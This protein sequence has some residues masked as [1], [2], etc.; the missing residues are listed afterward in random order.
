MK[1]SGKQ[2]KFYHRWRKEHQKKLRIG[3]LSHHFCDHVNMRL[4]YAFLGGCNGER[5]EVFA[6]MGGKEDKVTGHLMGLADGWRDISQCTAEEAARQIYEDGI[7]IL[8]DFS[9]NAGNRYLPIL[10]R[11][12]APVQMA[13]IGYPE[14][15]GSS[16]V[17][18]FLGDAF[19]DDG[20]AESK[21]AEEL[22][23]LPQS[24][25]CYMP[26]YGDFL[27][28]EAPCRRNGFVTFGSLCD[29]S[30]LK[31]ATLKAW[32][33]IMDAVPDSRL[34]L[35]A[36]VNDD[37]RNTLKRIRAM[38]IDTERVELR[39]AGQGYWKIYHEIDIAL[40]AFSCSNAGKI[41][42]ALYMGIP[43]VTLKGKS[44][45]E[46]FGWDILQN[47]GL[48]E[49]CARTEE[50]YAERA[51][52]LAGD[53]ELLAALRQ[54]LRG[55]MEN[56]PLMNRKDYMEAVEQGYEMVW[57]HFVAGQTVPS[58]QEARR[59]V[60]IFDELRDMGETKQALAVADRILEAKPESLEVVKKLCAIYIDEEDIEH[61]VRALD[62]MPKDL[63]LGKFLMG[64]MC[65]LQKKWEDAEALCMEVARTGGLDHPLRGAEHHVLGD[66]YKLCG[67]MLKSA[68]EYRLASS[69][70]PNLTIEERM[71]QY[72][73]YL[74]M[75]HFTEQTP[76]FMYREACRYR[77]YVKDVQPFSHDGRR[78][79]EKLRIGYISPDFRRHVVACFSQ[80]FFD[81]AD[82]ERFEVYAYAKC[83]EDDISR[84][85]AQRADVWRNI[86]DCGTRQAAR[87][88]YEDEIDIL[89][90]ISG[91]TA[92]NALTVMAL[93]PA[94][95]QLCGIGYFSTTGL[96]AVDYFLVDEHTAPEGEDAFFSE[97]L[98][99][100]PH[101]HFCYT[102]VVEVPDIASE[103][104]C[105]RNGFI[106]F[107][108]MNNVNKMSDGVLEAWGKLMKEIPES[109]LFL[110][111]GLLDD[112]ARRERE[113]IRLEKVGIDSSR[114]TM[115]GFSGDYLKEYRRMDIALDT[116]PYPGGGT[117][118]D[119][120]YMGVP[121]IT[122]AGSSNHERFGL[123]IL[124]NIG[125]EELCGG[126][127]EEY[128]ACAVG[129][130]RD[131][132]RL[133]KIHGSLRDR[134]AGSAV[135]NQKMYMKDLEEAYEAVWKRY[136]EDFAFGKI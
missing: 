102:Q 131:R 59:L 118:C 39:D 68:E 11:K 54:N 24:I 136:E 64:K 91:H 50:E 98:L 110:K 2:Q 33:G 44:H 108:S 53:G 32:A 99:R 18:Y 9:G 21:F 97:K 79:H 101:S 82:R 5:F 19:L 65:Y 85:M 57:E 66:V 77:D 120:L 122:L 30:E 29:V 75:L 71:E 38:G 76:E 43:V 92:N 22:L 48:G 111:H 25:F 132:E 104:P 27:V 84:R 4:L 113:R 45:G 23:V 115:E 31:K 83:R 46:R 8:V 89:V 95:V 109:H 6:Y 107:G 67:E 62:L 69:C 26:F 105:E 116:F 128:V 88:I 61:S 47:A 123:S 36:D 74:L 16:A 63:P 37:G 96:P 60:S 35:T 7:D 34:L 12:P 112:P 15:T 80:A 119:A 93:H 40:D 72:S 94:P 126:T 90:D 14:S 124:A 56:S 49:L 135:M 17:D 121:V 133:R 117:T 28:E 127:V 10:A 42:D 51:V 81:A 100:L 129:L 20:A 134:L 106:T 130:A 3:Y 87:M 13:G 1:K 58:K 55:M 73:N 70:P 125:L 114:I 103:L 86:R 41:C 78:R 52:M